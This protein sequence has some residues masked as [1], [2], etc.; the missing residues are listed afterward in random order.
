ML[1]GTARKFEPVWRV[2][3]GVVERAIKPE[4]GGNLA[5]AR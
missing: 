2:S 5:G 3:G 4:G 1:P